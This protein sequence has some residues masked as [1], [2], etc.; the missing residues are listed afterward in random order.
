MDF[1]VTIDRDKYIGG[2]DVPAIMGLSSFRTRWQLLLEKAGEN[3]EEAL[4]RSVK[5]SDGVMHLVK[6]LSVTPSFVVAKGGITSSDVG[7]KALSVKKALV[8]GQAEAGVPVWKTGDESK[9]PY[10]PY[11]IF[12]GN[13]GEEDTLKKIVEKLI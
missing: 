1:D 7:V 2:S 3:K 11:I 4:V 13:V 12:P 8:I 5:I 10:I 6:D 9:F